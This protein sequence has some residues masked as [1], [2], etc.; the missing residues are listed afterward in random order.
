MTNIRKDVEKSE[1]RNAGIF[2]NKFNTLVQDRKDKTPAGASACQVQRVLPGAGREGDVLPRTGEE[3]HREG[4]QEE[5]AQV[6]SGQG[7]RFLNF[8]VGKI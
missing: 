7:D 2:L 6:P 1:R 3:D 4:F 8:F 5:G